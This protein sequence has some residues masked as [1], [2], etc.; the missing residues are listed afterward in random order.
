MESRSGRGRE[1]GTEDQ[2]TCQRAN[3][4]KEQ[5]A[6]SVK[7]LGQHRRTAD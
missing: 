3:V 4:K 2:P 7:C 6:N 5:V 1:P